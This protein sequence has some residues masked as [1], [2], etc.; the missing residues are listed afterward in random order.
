MPTV[1]Q[2]RTIPTTTYTARTPIISTFFLKIDSEH[3]L[4]IDSEHL[5]IIW[6][7]PWTFYTA[8]TPI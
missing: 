1:Y 4:K 7:A 3:F 5:L 2:P 8:R 6:T